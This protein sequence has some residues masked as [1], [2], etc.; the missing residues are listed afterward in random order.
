M[1]QPEMQP[2]M[3]GEQMP[4]EEM[5]PQAMEAP[6][7]PANPFADRLK[8]SYPDREFASDDD[9]NSALTEHL[10]GLEGYQSST[11]ELHAKLAE[12]LDAEPAIAAIIRDI[13][14]GATFAEALSRNVDLDEI[15]PMEGDPDYEMWGQNMESRKSAKAEKEAGMQAMQENLDMSAA[16]IRAFAEENGMANEDATK[17][18]E[19]VDQL[20][21][22]I[23]SGKLTKQTL[24]R[25]KKALDYDMDVQ[26]AAQAGEVKGR[27]TKIDAVKASDKPIKGDGM[28]AIT[29]T[30]TPKP[31]PKAD[32]WSQAIDAENTKRNKLV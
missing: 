11:K 32:S 17:F 10:D 13:A 2:P 23:V 14:K 24:S 29:S 16:E 5:A 1:K 9:I 22:D 21:G 6:A 27:N 3:M 31:K 25:L 8:K 26:S 20:V 28:P 15:T 19:S 30:G 18:L 12:V 4:L 7:A